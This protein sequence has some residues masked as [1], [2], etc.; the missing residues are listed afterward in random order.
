M[1]Y[2]FDSFSVDTDLRELRRENVLQPVEPQVFDLLTYLIQNRYRVVS[3]DDIFSEVWDGRIVSDGAL[4]TRINTARHTI[5]DSGSKQSYIRTVWSKGFRFVGVVREVN[6]EPAAAPHVVE[7][8][9]PSSIFAERPALAV[10]PVLDTGGSTDQD[11]FRDDVTEDLITAFANADWLATCSRNSSF[12]YK[13]KRIEARRIAR[14]LGMR[15]LLEGS[16]RRVGDSV[17]FTARLIDGAADAQLWAGR[18]DRDCSVHSAFNDDIVEQIAGA[19]ANQVYATERMRA[20]NSLADNPSAW[21]CMVRALSLMNTRDKLQVTAGRE[22]MEKAIALDP[23][24]ARAHSLLSILFTL[25]VQQGWERGE[26]VLPLALHVANTALSI[27]PEESWAHLAL[28]FA[29]I[30]GCPEQ[31][32]RPLERSLAL[33]PNLA[34]GQ[35]LYALAATRTGCAQE[36]MQRADLASKLG[37]FDLLARGY[38]GAFNNVRASASFVIGNYHEGAEFAERAIAENPMLAP[39]YRQLVVNHALAGN[40]RKAKDAFLTL[41]RLTPEISW[42]WVKNDLRYARV[43]DQKRYARAFRLVGLT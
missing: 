17:R 26:V 18:Y 38:S 8:R 36:V 21:G 33:N 27:N 29:L 5:G 23:K 13:G 37:P 7:V 25:G 42:E 10:L 14:K 30:W 34:V 19:V 12:A 22:L 2:L 40:I 41:K 24:S 31:A 16:V 6:Q 1:R 11:S 32:M 4:S 9:P 15:Y 28:G 3:R 35:F 43:S 20:E 39:A